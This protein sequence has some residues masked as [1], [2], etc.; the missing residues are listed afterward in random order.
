MSSHK[1]FTI[2]L[3]KKKLKVARG[4]RRH[5]ADI[6]QIVRDRGYFNIFMETIFEYFPFCFIFSFLGSNPV[7]TVWFNTGHTFSTF[8]EA[9]L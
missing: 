4:Y 6:I 1:I 5:L 3:F 7:Y 2:L 9:F 8:L